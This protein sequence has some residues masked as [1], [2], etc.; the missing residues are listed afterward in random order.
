MDRPFKLIYLIIYHRD[1]DH[2]IQ[3]ISQIQHEDVLIYIHVDKKVDINSLGDLVTQYPIRF[4][5]NRITV[6]WGSFS[7]IQSNLNGIKEIL[8][9]NIHFDHLIILSGQDFPLVENQ[10]ILDHFSNFPNTSFVHHVNFF[11]SCQ[12]IMDRIS[13]YH[14][15]LPKNK[16]IVYPYSGKNIFKI[17]INQILEKSNLLKYPKNIVDFKTIYFGSNWVRLSYKAAKYIQFYSSSN[18]LRYFKQTL[19]SDE[20]FYQTILLH[21]SEDERGL[22]INENLTFTHWDRPAELYPSPL[23]LADLNRLTLSGKLFARK[24]DSTISKEL[25]SKIHSEM[26]N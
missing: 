25:L 19:N 3:L 11:D 7:I 1:K 10:K 21:A 4:V 26:M 13:K 2:L 16:M 15:F 8:Q 5:K 12:H 17:W 14:F 9:E 20:I 22:I 6:R 24:F 18:S 23:N